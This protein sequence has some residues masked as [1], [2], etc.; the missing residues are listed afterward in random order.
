M[1]IV[2]K[3]GNKR[4][5]KKILWLLLACF[6]GNVNA[7]APSVRNQIV[8]LTKQNAL[9][10]QTMVELVKIAEN[11]KSSKAREEAYNEFV[12]KA[13]GQKLRDFIFRLVATVRDKEN[14]SNSRVQAA[15]TLRKIIFS[16]SNSV[17]RDNL[18][19][20]SMFHYDGPSLI[21]TQAG[22]STYWNNLRPENRRNKNQHTALTN[23][24][25]SQ[26]FAK[27]IDNINSDNTIID[28]RNGQI[29]INMP[30]SYVCKK[31]P[32]IV[33]LQKRTPNNIMA[34]AQ[35]I[36]RKQVINNDALNGY[37]IM[38]Y[39]N[40]NNNGLINGPGGAAVDGLSG[41]CYPQERN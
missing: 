12:S 7:L 2:K 22:F 32:I 8:E 35:D 17:G 27:V 15:N 14:D 26:V 13:Q 40:I 37:E 1:S 24:E 20:H 19:Q 21:D 4:V 11:V 36:D 39:I 38:C 30:I 31:L 28:V 41:S 5:T 18:I 3:I 23:H 34:V 29:T 10:I 16:S 25:C 6:A 33:E 9:T